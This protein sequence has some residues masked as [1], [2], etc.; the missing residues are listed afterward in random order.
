MNGVASS[1]NKETCV[2]S[3][4]TLELVI[5]TEHCVAH[6]RS[7]LFLVPKMA[8]IHDVTCARFVSESIVQST[9]AWYT[10]PAGMRTIGLFLL[11]LLFFS[12]RVV[13]WWYFE[14]ETL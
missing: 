13:R 8:I 2:G 7:S 4:K 12:L 10:P 1:L 14:D 3:L 6:A 9:V 11:L 5:N